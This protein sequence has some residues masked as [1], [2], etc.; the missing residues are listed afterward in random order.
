MGRTITLRT[1]QL[2]NTSQEF[3]RLF[4]STKKPLY[5]KNVYTDAHIRVRQ[6]HYYSGTL[7]GYEVVEV[8]QD[9]SHYALDSAEA[10]VMVARLVLAP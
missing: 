6:V 2:P 1:R 3:E 4:E 9:L 8:K 7:S 5:F 10:Y